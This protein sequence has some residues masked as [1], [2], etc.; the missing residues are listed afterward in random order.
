M[1]W[2]PCP[3]SS[4][5]GRNGVGLLLSST[6]PFGQ[7]V[8]ITTRHLPPALHDCYLILDTSI[9]SQRV[10]IHVVY[11]PAQFSDRIQFFTSL[12]TDLPRD[13]QHIVLGNFNV[14]L[15]PTLGSSHLRSAGTDIDALLQW[16]LH[17]GLVDAWRLTHPS[18]EIASIIVSCRP[19][20]SSLRLHISPMIISLNITW[21]IIFPSRSGSS[22]LIIGHIH[23]NLGNARLGS[24]GFPRSAPLYN[25]H[26]MGLFVASALDVSTTLEL[27]MM[28]TS[29]M[30]SEQLHRFESLLD[31]EPFPTRAIAF[32]ELQERITDSSHHR[33]QSAA[34]THF[35]RDITQS[36]RASKYFFRPPTPTL[37]CV[38]IPSA[39]RPD[40]TITTDPAQMAH[41][42]NVYWADVFQ[43]PSKGYHP[44]KRSHNAPAMTE[45]LRHTTA[46]LSSDDCRI[47]ESPFTATAFY[48]AIK[49]S[50]P[51]K[52]PGYD[53]LPI[54]YYQLFVSEWARVL[55]LDGDRSQ[56]SYYR[57][58]TLL[59]HDAK[60]GPKILAYRLTRIL[61]KLLH[62]DQ[63]GFVQVRSIR[64]ALVHFQDIHTLCRLQ[65]RQAGAVLLDFAKGV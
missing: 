60:L 19:S 52:A 31:L 64:H 29:G 20:Y 51:D 32:S 58:I 4:S 3:A 27:S 12:P 40:G 55:E 11:A 23:G 61:P 8:N 2:S 16:N 21:P 44:I 30:I 37:H 62:S 18:E 24:L 63:N 59:N 47:L 22:T 65:Y 15:D 50:K 45:L 9:L 33:K 14:P 54:E 46:S 53:G 39:H 26:Y 35:D 5:K 36:E 13:V 6:H 28:N 10:W 41:A 43:S 1:F 56:P 49:S 34:I 17:V 42:H 25:C 48:W 57:P 38:C 7:V